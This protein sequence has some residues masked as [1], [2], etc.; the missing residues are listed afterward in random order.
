M[1][2]RDERKESILPDLLYP[3]CFGPFLTLL[4][5]EGGF[6]SSLDANNIARILASHQCLPICLPALARIDITIQKDEEVHVQPRASTAFSF[7]EQHLSESAT[8]PRCPCLVICFLFNYDRWN[9]HSEAHTVQVSSWRLHL[10]LWRLGSEISSEIILLLISSKHES[11]VGPMSSEWV[12][13]PRPRS[14]FEVGLPR[15]TSTTWN[16]AHSRAVASAK[17]LCRTSNLPSAMTARTSVRQRPREPKSQL[18]G[19]VC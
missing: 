15:K 13:A 1:R 8:V 12:H 7:R 14:P 10:M 4:V 18:T 6:K 2:P 5:A 11:L 17:T 3:F 9:C 16:P 19:F